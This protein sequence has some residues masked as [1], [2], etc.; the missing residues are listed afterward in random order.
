MCAHRVRL[1]AIC[2]LSSRLP[3]DPPQYHRASEAFLK[4]AVGLFV[5]SHYKNAPDD[6]QVLSDAPAHRIFALLAPM[7]AGHT[8]LPDIL[9][10]VQVAL[11]GAINAEAVAAG[12][13]RDGKRPAGDLIP[14]TLTQQFQDNGFAQMSGARVVRI[15]THAD[16]QGLG[17]GKRALAQL[18]DFYAGKLLDVEGLAAAE[19]AAAEIAVA[20][21]TEVAAASGNDIRP[22][23]RLQPLLTP[24]SEV[25]PDALDYVG[26][27]FGLTGS[28]L[29]FWRWG[30]FRPLYCR[31]R[32]RAS[33]R[34][35]VH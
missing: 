2:D 1:C 26:V 17:Y 3:A 29:K 23:A 33:T 19:A 14:W 13:A 6:L 35:V 25:R 34:A 24:V 32:S 7:K 27:S 30:G 11:E 20:A 4:R 16:L 9:C 12:L 8:G 22:R 28:L 21:S 18:T 5:A 15:A 31:L 10:V